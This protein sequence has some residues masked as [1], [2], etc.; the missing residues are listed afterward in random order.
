MKAAHSRFFHLTAGLLAITLVSLTAHSTALAD[1]ENILWNFG[2]F[3][4]D[5]LGPFAG[6]I[7]DKSGNFY[8]TTCGGGS[9][10]SNGNGGTVFELSPPSGVG[11]SWT[12]SILADF[13]KDSANGTCPMGGLVADK[14]GNLFGT[15]SVL[16]NYCGAV[17]ELFRPTPGGKWTEQQIYQFPGDFDTCPDGGNPAATMLIDASGNLYGT[18]IRGGVYDSCD[19]SICTGAVFKLTPPSSPGGQWTESLP[20]SFGGYGTDGLNPFGGLVMDHAGSLYG[21]TAG[22]GIHGYGT[23][24]RL[25]PPATTGGSW[26]ESKLWNFAGAPDG[27]YPSAGLTLGTD[28]AL[29]G[30]TQAGGAFGTN[31]LKIFRFDTLLDFEVIGVGGTVFKLI[32][33]STPGGS[34]SES[35]LWSF[36]DGLNPLGQLLLDSQ[37]NLYGT[38][39]AGGLYNAAS[40]TSRFIDVGGTVFKL[41]PPATGAGTWTESTLWNFGSGSDGLSPIAGLLADSFGNFFGTTLFGGAFPGASYPYYAGTVFEVSTVAGPQISVT[42]THLQFP[43]TAVGST[44]T[45]TITVRNVGARPGQLAG[46]L[47]MPPAPFG[48]LGAQRSTFKLDP[49]AQTTITLTFT[50]SSATTSTVTDVVHSDA[51]NSRSGVIIGLR[52]TGTGAM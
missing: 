46:T 50:P 43:P 30:T 6:L 29:Y 27:A 51:V 40:P 18:T 13:G 45:A 41:S 38:T 23:V 5:G 9:T 1:S 37:G 42:P 4:G 11:S 15:K 44:S 36:G 3:A 34:W 31:P 20:W 47:L 49:N 25:R 52:G 2:G 48:I 35:V 7:A 8:G 26:T 19:E 17:F 39:Q 12:E 10:D 24:F 22:G 33:P 14:Q 16:F 21:T 32:P 28:G